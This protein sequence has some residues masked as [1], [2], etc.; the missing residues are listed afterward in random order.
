MVPVDDVMSAATGLGS[1]DSGP[2]TGLA[3]VGPA[4]RDSIT[5]PPWIF[6]MHDPGDWRDIFQEAGKTGWVMFNQWAT[7]A[8]TKTGAS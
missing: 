8:A 3:S 6:G 1:S 5:M 2:L 4:P 7:V